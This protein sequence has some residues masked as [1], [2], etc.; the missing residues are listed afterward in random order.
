M[1]ATKFQ[2]TAKQ[3]AGMDLSMP[4][5]EKTVKVWRALNPEVC[6]LWRDCEEAFKKCA[7]GARE[8][9]VNKFLSFHNVGGGIVSMRLPSGRELFYHEAK[10]TRRGI[11]FMTTKGI[12]ETWGGHLVENAVQAIARDVI[13]FVMAQLEKLFGGVV[14]TIHDEIV[15]AVRKTR[16]KEVAA[17]THRIMKIAPPWAPGLPLNAETKIAKRLTK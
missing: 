8:V 17:E 3:Q 5:C 11:R 16:S 9:R 7:N 4:M 12:E 10:A 15:Q 6:K 13:V 2:G 14:L 1:G